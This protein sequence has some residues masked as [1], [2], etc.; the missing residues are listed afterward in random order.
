MERYDRVT[1]LIWIGVGIAQCIQSWILGL[2]SGSEPGTG[3]MPFLVGLV[4]IILSMFLLIGSTIAARENPERKISLWS[5]T[6]WKRVVYISLVLLMYA[7]LLPKLGY[8]TATFL[9]MVF[10]LKSGEPIKWSVAI[11]LGLL[12]SSISYLI[13]GIWLNILF[14]EGVLSF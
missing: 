14:P 7:L 5:N 10:L 12:T 6:Y 13:F 9:A 1:S 8:L 4:I 3:F 2:G 11:I